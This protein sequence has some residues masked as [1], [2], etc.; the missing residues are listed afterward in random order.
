MLSILESNASQNPVILLFCSN[1]FNTIF[2]GIEFTHFESLYK[3][4]LRVSFDRCDY[5]E[6]CGYLQYL[7]DKFQGTSWEY[8]RNDL[9]EVFSAI[10]RDISIPYRELKYLTIQ[11]GYDFSTFKDLINEWEEEGDIFTATQD[12]KKSSPPTASLDN[13]KDK[14]TH[15]K[16]A[17][18]KGKSKTTDTV[19][20]DDPD[21]DS[22][23][24]IEKYEL[25]LPSTFS[26]EESEEEIDPQDVESEEEEYQIIEM[27]EESDEE[28]G[29]EDE[30]EEEESFFSQV[31]QDLEAIHDKT[32]TLDYLRKQAQE[33]PKITIAKQEMVYV[34]KRQL[35]YIST[36]SGRV[37]KCKGY[38]EILKSLI[39]YHHA[40]H[41]HQNMLRTVRRKLSELRSDILPKY[42][43]EEATLYAKLM[44]VYP[45]LN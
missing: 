41:E 30:G 29:G 20:F 36:C 40:V 33:D 28:Q 10:R 38:L 2:E 39:Y 27:S 37:N 4:F 17:N 31:Q 24:D 1:I 14:T 21:F 32:Y 19:D 7:N 13:V 35:N 6:L 15:S 8:S 45:E 26:D 23:A 16:V 44:Q 5:N 25:R 12:T 22:Q 42:K 34:I 3:R 18:E 43:E 9:A 11:A